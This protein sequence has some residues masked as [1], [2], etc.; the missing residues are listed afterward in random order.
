[1]EKHPTAKWLVE[2][3]KPKLSI[4][5][6]KN[7]L[8]KIDRRRPSAHEMIDVMDSKPLQGCKVSFKG[9]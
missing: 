3:V 1:M 4:E 6:K 8:L 9:T 2:Q 7:V 5:Q